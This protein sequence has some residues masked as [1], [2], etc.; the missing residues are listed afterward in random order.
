MKILLFFI[1]LILLV[2]F[3]E[4]NSQESSSSSDDQGD[5]SFCI[6]KT[7][8]ECMSSGACC[9]WCEGLINGT[10]PS[11]SE[12]PTPTPTPTLTPTPTPSNTTGSCHF[13]PEITTCSDMKFEVCANYNITQCT[14][15]FRGSNS[16]SNFNSIHLSY[17][18]FLIISISIFLNLI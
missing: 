12:T 3:K 10:T 18:V 8:Y 5:N 4:C 2:N 11:P 9:V 15:N 16:I 7:A 6:G 13:I 1:L 14:C 17:L